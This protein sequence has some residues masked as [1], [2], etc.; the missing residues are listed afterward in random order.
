MNKNKKILVPLENNSYEVTVKAGIINKIGKELLKIGIKNERKILIV[1]NKEISS[2]YGDKLLEDLQINNFEVQMFLIKAGEVHKN[3]ETLNAIYNAAFEFGLDRNSLI[4]ALG[5]GIVGDITG[6]AAATW[7]RGIEYI[8]IPTTLLSMVDSSVGGK[9]AVNHPKGKNLIGAFHQPKAVFIDPE[10]LKTLP[11]RE[12]RAGMAEVI[13]YGVIKDKA[14]FE[15]LE[16]K[17]NQDKLKNLQNETLIEIINSS[18]KTK[19][20]I[21]TEDEQE[22][23]IRAILNYGHSFGHVIENLCGYGEYLHGE[24]ISIGMKIA[25]KISLEKGFWSNEEFLR[26]ENLLKSYGLPTKAPKINKKDVLEILMGDKKVLNGKMR[27]ILPT[28]I[29][30]VGI[31]DDIKDSLFL[32]YF[33]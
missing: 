27:F 19:S 14:L 33:S 5:G 30:D 26:Q 21:V 3:L 2:L 28:K 24:A 18:I 16:K 1:S 8:Q 4:I 29:G 15:F 9:T 31:Y 12:F 6:L 11:K 13:K 10:T 25:G 20:N 23:G 32:K 7:L 17:P 22:K